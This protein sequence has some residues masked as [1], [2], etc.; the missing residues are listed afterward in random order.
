MC[1]VSESSRLVDCEWNEGVVSFG[2]SGNCVDLCC[3]C[4]CFSLVFFF[5]GCDV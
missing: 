1:S 4:C 3:R 5:H 2:D